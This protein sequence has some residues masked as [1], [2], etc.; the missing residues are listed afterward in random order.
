MGLRHGHT[1]TTSPLAVNNLVFV[2]NDAGTVY[3]LDAQTGEAEWKIKT[4]TSVQSSPTVMDGVLFVGGNDR[5]VHALDAQTGE[6]K[7]VFDTESKTGL[8]SPTAMNGWVFVG[9]EQGAVSALDTQ[10]GEQ[11]WMFNT[12]SRVTYRVINV[13]LRKHLIQ[14]VIQVSH[15]APRSNSTRPNDYCCEKCRVAVTRQVSFRYGGSPGTQP[16]PGT[17]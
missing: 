15:H 12:N 1:V 5:R 2:G 6:R 14:V 17:F 7:W 4:I 11:Q 8:S 9:N 10:T 16:T 13:S 3:A